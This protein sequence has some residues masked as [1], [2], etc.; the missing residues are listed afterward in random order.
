MHPPDCPDWEYKHHRFASAVG[1]R[2]EEILHSLATKKLPIDAT[3]RDT[4]AV[5][6]RMFFN[7]TPERCPYY[8]GHY[9]GEKFRCLRHMKVYHPHDPRVG[10]DAD[11]VAPDLANL[12]S[13]IVDAGLKALEVSFAL[14][15]DKL[16]AEDKLYNLVV[17]VCRV[18]VEFLRI[19]PYANGNGH[20]G[21]MIVWLI[22]IRFGYW[23]Q[24]WELDGH[25]PYNELLK[26]FRD[27][28]PIP[29]HNFVLDCIT[30]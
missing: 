9:R 4:R 29:L 13:H 22:L 12:R 28:D 16:P 8:A 21:R 3:L 17:F 7:L 27:G 2:C 11:R 15:D 6:E 18:L 1:L 25:P 26:Q 14:S 23:P 30:G 19:H 20:A 10:V 24:K 5:H